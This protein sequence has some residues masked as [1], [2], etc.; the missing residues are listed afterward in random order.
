MAWIFQ[1]IALIIEAY[2]LKH[3]TYVVC[4]Y[5]YNE[6]VFTEKKVGLR[7]WSLALLI[8]FNALHWIFALIALVAVIVVVVVFSKPIQEPD[9]LL[10]YDYLRIDSK[11]VD[12]IKS[13]LTKP[14]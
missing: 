12:I 3:M 7:V 6:P 11:L 4:K 10:D 9:C 5:H 1:L 2:L 8:G 14:L 13:F